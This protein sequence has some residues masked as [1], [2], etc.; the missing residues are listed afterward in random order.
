MKRGL[1]ICEAYCLGLKTPELLEYMAL[2]NKKKRNPFIISSQ[3]QGKTD[4]MERVW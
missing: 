3:K 2:E 1:G 4:A